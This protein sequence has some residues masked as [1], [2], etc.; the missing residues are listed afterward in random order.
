[1]GQNTGMSK[2]GKNVI[3]SPITIDRMEKYLEGED[4]KGPMRIEWESK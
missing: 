2:K 3:T 1:M 4:I